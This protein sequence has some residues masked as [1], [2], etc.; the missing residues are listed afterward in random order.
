MY[1]ITIDIYIYTIKNNIHWNMVGDAVAMDVNIMHKIMILILYNARKF[2]KNFLEFC[3][4]KAYW[5]LL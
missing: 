1:A 2:E 4:S 5:T 3:H